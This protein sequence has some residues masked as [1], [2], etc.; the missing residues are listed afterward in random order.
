MQGLK[1]SLPTVLDVEEVEETL[2]LRVV[3]EKLRKAG[4]NPLRHAVG[5]AVEA[6][7]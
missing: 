3:H 2:A 5:G 7:L 1:R 6:V 4:L